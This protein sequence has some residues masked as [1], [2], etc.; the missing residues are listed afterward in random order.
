[1]LGFEE[2][3]RTGSTDGSAVLR[4]AKVAANLP[5][6][7]R[8]SPFNIALLCAR[9]I[10]CTMRCTR[11]GDLPRRFSLTGKSGSLVGLPLRDRLRVSTG[12]VSFVSP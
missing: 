9:S 5:S 12:S 10:C 11:P 7:N 6:S 4:L 8:I 1:M 2:G 3:T